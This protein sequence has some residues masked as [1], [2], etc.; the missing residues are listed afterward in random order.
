MIGGRKWKK[1]DE[2]KEIEEMHQQ[3]VTQMIKSAEGS[4]TLAQNHESHS[5]ERR[6][7][8]PEETR[9]RLDRCDAKW[10]GKALAV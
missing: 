4:W 7:A 3:K 1:E 6:S 2:K 8:D 5:M 9:R 10:R